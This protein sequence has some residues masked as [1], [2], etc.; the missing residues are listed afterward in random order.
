MHMPFISS[1]ILIPQFSRI[2][3]FLK[4]KNN[5]SDTIIV[6]TNTSSILTKSNEFYLFTSTILEY[7][8][9]FFIGAAGFSTLHSVTA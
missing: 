1:Y 9:F 5:M 7:F 6:I 4:D 2:N 3:E 8:F